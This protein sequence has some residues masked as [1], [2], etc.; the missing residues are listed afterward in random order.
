MATLATDRPM[1]SDFLGQTINS[2]ESRL[3]DKGLDP[4]QPSEDRQRSVI[5]C[6]ELCFRIFRESQKPAFL[7]GAGRQRFPT[8]LYETRVIYALSELYASNPGRI[9]SPRSVVEAIF[10]FFHDNQLSVMDGWKEA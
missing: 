1:R 7:L 4:L 6:L 3:L 10:E 5:L 2:V 9:A 8:G